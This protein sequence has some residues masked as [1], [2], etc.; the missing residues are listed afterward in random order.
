MITLILFTIGIAATTFLVPR[1]KL[2]ARAIFK[3]IVVFI[4]PNCSKQ[5]L[6]LLMAQTIFYLGLRHYLRPLI[7]LR[8]W[9]AP[10]A[11]IARKGHLKKTR[12]LGQRIF[13]TMVI[14]ITGAS[15]I[16]FSSLELLLFYIA[17]ETTL[18]PTLIL[19]T[20][21]GAQMERFQAGL[22]LCFI[23]YSALCHYLLA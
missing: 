23:H 21:W 3:S 13:I 8:C 20:R 5:P 11:L 18:I 19:I 4:I 12:D 10:I 9:L 1:N 15:I 16:T 17:F 7:I 2:W 22:Y 6:N 14:I